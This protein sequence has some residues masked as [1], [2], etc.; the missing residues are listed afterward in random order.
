MDDNAAF[1]KKGTRGLK[2]SNLTRMTEELV[3]RFSEKSL[4][5]SVPKIYPI[6]MDAGICYT[7]PMKYI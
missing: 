6:K 3:A 4:R 5:K 1:Y 2:Q 7:L